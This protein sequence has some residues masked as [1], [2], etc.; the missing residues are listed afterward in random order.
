MLAYW[1]LFAFFAIGSLFGPV[2]DRRDKRLGALTIAWAVLV[3]MIGLRWHVGADWNT[4]FASWRIAGTEDFI[5]FIWLYERDPGFYGLMWLFREMGLPFW[6]LNLFLAAVFST[7]LVAFARAQPS[8]WLAILVAVP[9]LVIVV[10]MSG[11][12]QATAIGFVL[13]ALVAFQRRHALRFLIYV[14]LAATFHASAILILPFAGFSFSRTKFQGA[15]LSIAL[16]LGAYYSLG[17]A[18]SGY[19][20]RYLSGYVIRSSGTIVR[21]GMNL[22]AAMIFL[23]FRRSFVVP[24]AEYLLWRNMSFAT[25][26]CAILYFFIASSTVLDRLVLY[27]FPLQIFVFGSLPLIIQKQADRLFIAL[28]ILIYLGLQLFVFLTFGVNRDAYLPYQTVL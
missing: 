16:G 28:L 18:F 19:S 2:D 17:S 11:V 5:R 4:Y 22:V 20:D 1:M 10:A 3:F 15:L 8:P 7:G 9:Y 24:R 6:A 14:V 27:L 21:I 12:R 26:T 25:I 13:L 23:F